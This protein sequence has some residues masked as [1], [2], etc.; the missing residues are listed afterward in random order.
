MAYR[1]FKHVHASAKL[2]FLS[3]IFVMFSASAFAAETKN[4]K[5]MLD[6]IVQATHAPFFIAQEKGYYKAGG[7]T[8]DAIDAGRGAGNAAT[9]VASGTYHFSYVDLPSMIRFNAQNPN[10]PLIAVY[11]AFDETQSAIV[12]LKKNGIN[13]PGDLEGKKIA[14]GP[15]TAIRD[16]ISILLHAAGVPN[17][18]INWVNVSP[19]LYAPMMLRGE[20]DGIG[21][22]TNAQI[23][24]AM[25]LGVKRDDIGVLKYSDFGADLYGLA[26]V[27]TKKF[28]DENPETVRAVVS[29]FN[30][31]T[32][33]AIDDPEKALDLMRK[34]DPM[35]KAEFERVRLEIVL[36][37]TNTPHTT[38]NGLSSVTP[39]RL[40]RTIDSIAN[41][42]QLTT[43]PAPASIYTDKFLPPVAE[44][45]PPKPSKG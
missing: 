19:Q 17:V 31:G 1:V 10:S 34:R 23:P 44:R 2:S 33:D 39:E 24:A 5:I 4:V 37:H 16:T 43:K 22:F 15:G 14:G 9:S 35:M 42:Y 41:A 40:Q 27:T 30:R 45:M 3:F 28:A 6:W 12:T 7:V 20:V 11:M 32:K 25:E 21:A 26:L 8:V 36:G 13:K 38:K 29:A 18:Q